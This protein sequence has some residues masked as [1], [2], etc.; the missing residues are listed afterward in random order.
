MDGAP[1]MRKVDLKLYSC[2]LELSTT[3][4]KMFSCFTI[5]QCGSNGV[6]GRD[7]LTWRLDALRRVPWEMFIDSC[8]RLQIMKGSEAIGLAPRAMEKCKNRN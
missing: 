2:Y 8:K 3:L 4:E 1:Y 6:P 7:G 5:G